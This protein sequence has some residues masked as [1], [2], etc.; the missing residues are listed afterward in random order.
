MAEILKSKPPKPRKLEGKPLRGF[1]TDP[2]TDMMMD[3]L[4][5]RHGL[6]RSDVLRQAI[7]YVYAQ[8]FG[9]GGAA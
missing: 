9:Q 1:R 3:A 2:D 8:E 6:T 4:A 7:A 5:R